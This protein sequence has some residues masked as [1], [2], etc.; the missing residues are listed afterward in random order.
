M[1]EANLDHTVIDQEFFVECR[2][3]GGRRTAEGEK[4]EE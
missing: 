2:N 3:E 1:E 4:D